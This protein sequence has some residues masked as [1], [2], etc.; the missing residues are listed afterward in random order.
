MQNVTV[1]RDFSPKICTDSKRVWSRRDALGSF[2]NRSCNEVSLKETLSL[3][4]KLTY[5][6]L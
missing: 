2:E 5:E 1:N 6:R 4:G 3:A